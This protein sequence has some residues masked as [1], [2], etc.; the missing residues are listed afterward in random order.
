[1]RSFF[2]RLSWAF[3]LPVFQ[4]LVF[5]HIRLFGYATPVV[6]VHILCVMPLATSRSAWL[7]WGF[8]VGLGADFFSETP[9]LG[10][11]SM[12]FTALCAPQLLRLFAPKDCPEDMM[13]GYRTLGRWNHF[14]Y[15]TLLV[16]LQQASVMMLEF[17]SF[18]D[19]LDMLYTY[20]GSS[21]LSIVLILVLERMRGN[22]QSEDS[23]RRDG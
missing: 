23:D 15:V 7:L 8:A 1:M 12:T 13:P 2:S 19:A 16:S 18:F 17:F 22:G 14:W 20:L 5:N 10:A 21:A 6:Y 9:G 4:G 3:V 11:A